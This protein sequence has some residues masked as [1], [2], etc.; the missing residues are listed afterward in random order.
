MKIL[1]TSDW[2]LGAELKHVP[3]LDD[4]LTRVEEILSICDE[5][6]V[7][8]LLIVGD[9]MNETRSDRM[10]RI[11]RPF[12][13]LLRPRLARGLQVAVLAGNHDREWLFPYLQSV[14]DLFID[15]NAGSLHFVAKPQL[16]KVR[17]GDEAVRLMCLPYPRQSFYDLEAIAFTDAADRHKQM[18]DAVKQRITQFQRTITQDPEK[19]PTVVVAHLLIAGQ[20]ANDHELTEEADVPVPQVYLPNYAY[21]ALGHVHL[22]T[23]IGGSLTCR[24]CGS[25]ERMDFGECDEKKQVVLFEVRGMELVGDPEPID[26]HPT[27]LVELEWHESDDLVQMARGIAP[28]AICK[29]TVCVPIG[30]NVQAVQADARRLIP[31]LCWPPEVRWLGDSEGERPGLGSLALERDDWQGAVRRYVEEQVAED[32]EQRS[33]IP[34]LLKNSSPRRRAHDPVAVTLSNFLGY[35]DNDGNGYTYDF[36]DHRLWSISG[37]NGAGKSAIF[38]AITYCLFGKHRGGAQKHEQLLHKGTNKLSCSFTFD[39]LEVRYRVRRT[40]TKKTRRTGK[41]AFDSACQVE[42]YDDGESA[43]R[44]IDDTTSVAGLDEYVR[45]RPARLRL[46]HL[47]LFGAP[48]SGAERQADIGSSSTPIRLPLWNTC[49]RQ[50]PSA[51]HQI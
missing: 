20:K 38:D 9:F 19:M 24:Y 33:E 5:R 14:R 31:R 17:T 41:V 42:W 48:A 7:D 51:L 35:D 46:R 11:L 25:M 45:T 39:H 26:L 36:S 43:W 37:D 8:L 16:I 15:E 34:R 21:S 12:G 1:H 18:A 32:D 2:H 22:P 40:L 6:S 44:A 4:Q 3:R 10:T 29:L 30:A 23:L 47:H 28:N 13:E 27:E 49:I 50:V